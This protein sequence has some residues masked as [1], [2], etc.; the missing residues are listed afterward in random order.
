MYPVLSLF[1]MSNQMTTGSFTKPLGGSK[2]W[3]LWNTGFFDAEDYRF[4][5]YMELVVSLM[6]ESTPFQNTRN[7][8]WC[9][10]PYLPESG[11]LLKS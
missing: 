3:G 9:F 6:L 7:R 5:K 4:L 2:V 10:D 11:G 8:R 1:P